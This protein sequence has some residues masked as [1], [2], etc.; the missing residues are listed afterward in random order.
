MKHSPLA[1]VPLVAGGRNA[2]AFSP[3]CAVNWRKI[4]SAI[5]VVASLSLA[6]GGAPAESTA[7]VALSP[8]ISKSTLLSALDPAKEITIQ[9]SLP[10]SDSRGAHDLLQH[11]SDSKDPLFRQYISVEEFAARFGANAA[12]FAAVKQWAVNNQLV[13]LHESS[14]RTSLTVRGT[15][16]QME[17]LFL[18]Q[19]NNYRSATGDEFYSASV[20]PTLPSEI[21]SKIRG[22]VGLTGGVQ[23]ASLYKIGKVIGENPE[24]S[25]IR[26]NAGTGPGGGYA[27]NDLKTAYSIP[28]LGSLVPQ[29]V[30]IFEQGGIVKSDVTKYEKYFSL[31]DVPIAVTGVDGSDTSANGTIVEVDL[32]IDAILGL[33]PSVE[34]IHVY[35]ADYETISFSI[36]LVDTFDEIAKKHTAQTLSVSYGTDEVVQGET[37]IENEDDALVE[38]EDAGI[39][40]VVSAGDDGAYGRTGTDTYPAKLNAPDPGSQ[41]LVTCVGGTS[42]ATTSTQQYDGEVVWNDLSFD[43]GATGG[44]VS[45]YWSLPDFQPAS[46]VTQNG[47]SSTN[48][49]VPDVAAVADPQT[50]YAVYAASEGGWFVVGGTSLS[51]PLWASYLSILNS[52]LQYLNGVTTPQVGYFDPLLYA[53]LGNNY[54]PAGSLYPI[55]DGSNGDAALYGTAGYNAGPNYN[56]CTGLGSLWGPAGYEVFLYSGTGKDKPHAPTKITVKPAD[57]SAVISWPKAEGA[58]GYAVFVVDTASG[59]SSGQFLL[60]KTLKIKVTGLTAGQTYSVAVASVNK[61]GAAEVTTSFTTP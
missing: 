3:R 39:T 58:K 38:C 50:G 40:V 17:R 22:V 12:D 21:A 61:G 2:P 13:I 47:G 48:R 6:A 56:N 15:V 23:K 44:G 52:G 30:A 34:E 8:A 49:N 9:L 26:T 1:A 7:T 33:N 53:A 18:T 45:A 55:L 51:A 41:P 20:A 5:F 10:L 14:A 19:L 57:T 32:D 11:L 54:A 16:A 35:V 60:T 4:G 29:K 24:T 27:P 42:L 31:P 25:T 37:A 59:T 43:E 36:G 46:L 28:A